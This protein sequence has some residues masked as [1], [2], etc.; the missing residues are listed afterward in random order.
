VTSWFGPNPTLARPA[1]SKDANRSSASVVQSTGGNWSTR[2]RS[3]PTF[4]ADAS[5]R[6]PGPGPRPR[7]GLRLD[8]ERGDGHDPW[9]ER[10]MVQGDELG[11]QAM[12]AGHHAEFRLERVGHGDQ[13]TVQ[14]QVD[15]PLVAG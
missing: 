1:P 14:V 15:V 11:S 7:N 10:R 8:D 12:R 4:P 13:R 5:R 3:E 2:T 6:P 9:R